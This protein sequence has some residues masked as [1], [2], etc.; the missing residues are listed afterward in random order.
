MGEDDDLQAALALSMQQQHST[1]SGGN[2]DNNN[3]PSSP[4]AA[5]KRSDM[6]SS[7]TT[8]PS[9]TTFATTISLLDEHGEFNCRS[10]HKLIWND[11]C[12]TIND[13]ERWI[14]ECISTPYAVSPLNT[15]LE[16]EASAA[17][18]NDND[19]DDDVHTD[20]NL[21]SLTPLEVFTECRS[22]LSTT[23]NATSTSTTT[24]QPIWSIVQ[25]VGGPCG[26]LASIQAEIIRILLFGR[27]GS[28]T[29]ELYYPFTPNSQDNYSNCQSANITYYE[30]REALGMSIGMILARAALADTLK[31]KDG[32]NGLLKNSSS[33]SNNNNVVHLILPKSKEQGAAA[34]P[35][36]VGWIEEMLSTSSSGADNTTTTAVNNCATSGLKVHTIS[37]LSDNGDDTK[38][39]EMKRA[40]SGSGV[41]FR[42]PGESSTAETSLSEYQIKLIALAKAVTKYLLAEEKADE[43]EG[44]DD[45]KMDTAAVANTSSTN[46]LCPLDYFQG[47]G[48]VMY[49]VMSLTAT[50]G[51]DRIRA[52]K[53]I[54]FW[55]S[56]ICGQYHSLSNILT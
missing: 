55:P 20:N 36:I 23:S 15:T 37:S 56:F 24:Q 52:G 12:T 21:R 27:G 6:D 28:H 53:C 13:K 17:T 8:L 32:N 14:Y 43:G 25:S 51:I 1:D 10:F 11:T 30:V 46:V 29:K 3:A 5:I 16:F 26:V 49:L 44:G 39:P 38:M 34:A 2:G 22:S 4:T 7:Y 31:K 45:D 41:S 19:K 42:I 33:N 35:T 18:A 9:I 54:A 48:G 50:R 40:R 47:P